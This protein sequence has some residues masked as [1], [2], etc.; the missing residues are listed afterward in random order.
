MVRIFNSESSLS[1][2]TFIEYLKKDLSD[3]APFISINKSALGGNEAIYLAVSLTP[4]NEWYNGIFE[5]SQYF[6]MEIYE[7]GEMEVFT[8]S[9][10]KK[11]HMTSYEHRIK[12]KFRKCTA[13]HLADVVKR[14]KT[15]VDKVNV[16]INDVP[17]TTQI[18]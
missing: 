12:T 6:R 16:D 13:K 11:G 10:Y 14:I 4:K 5:N 3:V 15:F 18:N 17:S 2:N 7:N 1:T 9:L 8:Q